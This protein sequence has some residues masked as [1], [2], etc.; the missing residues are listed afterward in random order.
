MHG[1]YEAHQGQAL[2]I[3]LENI[4][5]PRELLS[6]DVAQYKL[7]EVNRQKHRSSATNMK[8]YVRAKALLRKDRI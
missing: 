7:H 6:S 8:A 1:A 2:R 3:L 4:E 5:F